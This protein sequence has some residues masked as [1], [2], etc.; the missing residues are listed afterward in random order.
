MQKDFRSLAMG[1]LCALLCACATQRAPSAMN[2]D[3]DRQAVRARVQMM[4]DR[5][6]SNDA[7]GVIALLDPEKFLILGSDVS[8]AIDTT[9]EL[10]TLMAR[11]FQM[12]GTARFSELRDFDFRS[13]GTL[14]TAYF[15]IS[16]SAGGGPVIPIRLTTTWRKLAGQWV[17]TQ[18]ANSVPTQRG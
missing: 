10:R 8:E 2:S 7:A 6:E 5:Y 1:V 18:S 14:A 12:W 15:L 3:A 17:L 13:D 4:L 11:D 9:D 16:F